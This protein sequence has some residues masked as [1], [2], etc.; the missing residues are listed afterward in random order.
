MFDLLAA[1]DDHDSD[2]LKLNHQ[3]FA[4]RL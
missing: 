4:S 1:S 3:G 2:P